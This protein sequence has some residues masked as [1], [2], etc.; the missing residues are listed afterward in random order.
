MGVGLELTARRKDGSEVAVEISLSPLASNAAARGEGADP[1]TMADDLLIT[2]FV[3]D[4]RERRALW[5]QLRRA[6]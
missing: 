5:A 4:V 1:R 6:R 2:A 3:R